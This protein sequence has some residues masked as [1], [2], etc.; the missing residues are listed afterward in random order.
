MDVLTA[1]KAGFYEVHLSL[2][3]SLLSLIRTHVKNGEDI[4]GLIET[5]SIVGIDIVVMQAEAFVRRIKQR[6]GEAEIDH[7]DSQH[8]TFVHSIPREYIP[9]P[10]T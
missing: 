8:H 10:T 7:L 3:I 4:I 9:K 6:K 5:G 1:I 2:L